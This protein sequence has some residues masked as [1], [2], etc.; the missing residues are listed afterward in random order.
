[1]RNQQEKLDKPNIVYY[2]L[3]D[4]GNT[5]NVGKSIYQ[6][7]NAMAEERPMGSGIKTLVYPVAHNEISI[8]IANLHD[9]FDEQM[10]PIEFDVK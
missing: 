1:M 8:R 2:A 5:Q 9:H 4:K 7:N 6:R 3:E 10:A